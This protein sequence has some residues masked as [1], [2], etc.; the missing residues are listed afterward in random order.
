MNTYTLYKFNTDQDILS[1]ILL[2]IFSAVEYL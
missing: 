2:Q 1:T